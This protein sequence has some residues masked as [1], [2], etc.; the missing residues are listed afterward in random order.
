[1]TTSSYIQVVLDAFQV[2]AAVLDG[3]S[4]RGLLRI[5]RAAAGN[6][7]RINPADGIVQAADTLPKRL[8]GVD[9]AVKT[10]DYESLHVISPDASGLC[11][12]TVGD[13]GADQRRVSGTGAGRRD[14][15]APW[16]AESCCSSWSSRRI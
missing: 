6:A 7:S 11:P 2:D 3:G 1:M 4:T 10:G 9:V 12:S 16:L 13:V 14:V 8:W 5:V 15:Q